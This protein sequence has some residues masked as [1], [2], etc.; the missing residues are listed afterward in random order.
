MKNNEARKKSNNKDT[1]EKF[2]WIWWILDEMYALEIKWNAEI[3]ILKD[4]KNMIRNVIDCLK[5]NKG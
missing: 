5:K 3:K 1:M 4:E 2:R